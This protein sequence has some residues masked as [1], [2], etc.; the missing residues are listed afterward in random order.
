MA[1]IRITQVD[2]ILLL[3][4][5]G[6]RIAVNYYPQ[7]CA[8]P[9]NPGAPSHLWEDLNKQKALEKTITQ[10]LGLNDAHE[11]ATGCR[12]VEGYLVNYYHAIDFS[13]LVLGPTSENEILLSEVCNTVKKCLTAITDE[14]LKVEVIC[15]KLDSVFLILDDVV[16]GGIIMESDHNVIVKRLKGKSGDSSDHMPLN[17]AIYNIRN[18][19]IRNLLNS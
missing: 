5:Q 3:D 7:H 18:N 9:T 10:E 8:A 14:Q 1:Y 17:Q 19:V 2:A 13:I 6:G 12:M 11:G 16:D 4:R 15:N